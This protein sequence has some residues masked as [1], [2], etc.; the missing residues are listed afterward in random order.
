MKRKLALIAVM[1]LLV[2]LIF[3]A[4]NQTQPT[5]K[6]PRWEN[7]ETY[8]FKIA[9]ADYTAYDSY[10]FTTYPEGTEKYA[11]DFP[12][13]THAATEV[14]ATEEIRPLEVH[15]SYKVVIK[16]DASYTTLTTSQVIY[17]QYATEYLQNCAVWD[18]LQSQGYV[19]TEADSQFATTADRTV[20]VSAND[21][22]VK[23]TSETQQ[24]MESTVKSKGFY[25]GKTAQTVS[26]HDVSTK[27]DFD[28][29]VATVTKDGEEARE[30]KLPSS[31][32]VSLIDVNQLFL[33]ARSYDKSA[34]FAD[35]PTATVFNPVS[36][37]TA[38]ASFYV[39]V[40]QNAVLDNNG[41]EEKVK[42]NVV[43]IGIGSNAFMSQL[44]LP[45][46]KTLDTMP[47]KADASEN[48]SKYTVVR[49]RVGFLAYE[50]TN[51]YTEELLAAI[52]P[53]AA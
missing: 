12:I 21:V 47:S 18:K 42:L 23:F 48:V 53:T 28:K 26:A 30:Y 13:A 37:T 16:K 39:N 20:L 32:N 50:V 5:N 40:N 10:V 24:P 14:S 11:K 25:M 1:L 27:Y 34:A 15:G 17:A 46:L 45:K 2:T 7:E 8:D 22:Y 19:T 49:F 35:S 36:G 6:A 33:Y 9:L 3:T 31:A 38:T 51:F 52:R 29:K 4:C 41:I 43:S 44:T